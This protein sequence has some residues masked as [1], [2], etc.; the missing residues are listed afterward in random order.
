M[1]L[2]LEPAP[3]SGPARAALEAY[4]RAV[5]TSNLLGYDRFTRVFCGC[6]R[7]T[8]GPVDAGEFTADRYVPNFYDTDEEFLRQSIELHAWWL[9]RRAKT[10]AKHDQAGRTARVCSREPCDCPEVVDGEDAPWCGHTWCMCQG[11]AAARPGHHRVLDLTRPFDP[12]VEDKYELPATGPLWKGDLPYCARLVFASS[13]LSQYHYLIERTDGLFVYIATR[14]C[15]A[16]PDY[17]CSSCT[18]AIYWSADFD[19]LW[20][21]CMTEKARAALWERMSQ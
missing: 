20:T 11:D 19:R 8:Y 15:S 4:P 6:G 12:A 18:T 3:A 16:T 7:H 5:P 10:H 21:Q 13:D 2:P 14:D 1:N 9:E 17:R